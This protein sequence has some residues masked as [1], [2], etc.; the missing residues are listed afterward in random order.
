MDKN[1]PIA[2]NY[3]P[4]NQIP[5]T[6][7]VKEQEI[8]EFREGLQQYRCVHVFLQGSFRRTIRI[9]KSGINLKPFNFLLRDKLWLLVRGLMH[10][11]ILSNPIH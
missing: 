8:Q 1:I 3:I 6:R 10:H 9:Q 7:E 5:I 2:G 4:Q 11:D